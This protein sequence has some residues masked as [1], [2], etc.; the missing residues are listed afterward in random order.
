MKCARSKNRAG[1]TLR[2][3]TAGS[4]DESPCRA[5]HK[6]NCEEPARRVP[7]GRTALRFFW[8]V[9]LGLRDGLAFVEAGVIVHC[10][11]G[12]GLHAVNVESAAE[13]IDFVLEDAGVPAGGLDE[14]G[15]GAFVE[16]FDA[17]GAGA[18]DDGG[19]TWEA[20]AAFVKIFY[21]I[22]AVGD[23]GIDDYVKRDGVAFAFGEVVR[24]IALQQVF[25]VFDYGELQGLADLGGCE[26]YAGGVMHCVVHIANEALDF[27]AENFL[28][29]EEPGR[30]A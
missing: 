3:G 8:G 16:E 25:T 18:G 23:D 19:K 10:G 6:I 28:G 30:F 17:D 26:A 4:Q 9:G 22:A 1:A 5:I 21:F 7:T 11:E 24:G 29:R 2:I 20:E 15:F 13:V 27:F 12:A 14:V